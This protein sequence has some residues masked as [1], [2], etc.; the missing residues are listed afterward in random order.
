MLM[1]QVQFWSGL[2]VE[3][4]HTQLLEPRYNSRD[5]TDVKVCDS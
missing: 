4:E 5:P 1:K 3:P 2:G